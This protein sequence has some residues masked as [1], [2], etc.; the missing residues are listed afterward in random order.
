MNKRVYKP[1]KISIKYKNH[2]EDTYINFIHSMIKLL[3]NNIDF[4]K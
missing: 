3:I 1:Y 4:F 2:N